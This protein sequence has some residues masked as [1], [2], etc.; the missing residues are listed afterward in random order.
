MWHAGP[1]GAISVAGSGGPR[2][3]PRPTRSGCCR[4]TRH[5]RAACLA[6]LGFTT[7]SW[8]GALV[9]NAGGVLVDHGWVRVL[10][11]GHDRLPDIVTQFDTE[12]R[13]LTVGYDVMGGQFAWLQTEPDARPTMHY[14][15]P[16]ELRWVDLEQGYAEWL[17][18]MLDGSATRFYDTLRWPGWQTDVAAL[19]LD[20]GFNVWP[21]PFTMEGKD[22]ST[23]SRRVTP[24]AELISSTKTPPGNSGQR[25]TKAQTDRPHA[26]PR[27]HHGGYSHPLLPP[28]ARNRPQRL[29]R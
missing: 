17:H 13:V 24:L 19:A 22:L 3:P 2:S 26:C 6:A 18:M 5:G 7:K 28:V 1:Y 25:R 20:Q 21:P 14:F 11:S 12:A 9:S 15:S 27:F 8:L 23:V 29:V 4:P 10:A 16:D